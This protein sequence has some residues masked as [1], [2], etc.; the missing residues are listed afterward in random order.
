MV[1]GEG[2][3]N[4]AIIFYSNKESGALEVVEEGGYTPL[5]NRGRKRGT[6]FSSGVLPSFLNLKALY[7]FTCFC[8]IP[9][10]MCYFG[11]ME[12]ESE[13]YLRLMTEAAESQRK[14]AKDPNMASCAKAYRD[15]FNS[16][17]E[18][19]EDAKN[20]EA[21]E[22][23]EDAFGVSEIKI[24]FVCLGDEDYARVHRLDDE[25]AREIDNADPADKRA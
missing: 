2:G 25:I 9:S 18:M 4:V 15:L 7:S 8:P 16:Y 12:R 21:Q 11:N 24:T 19:Y 20:R 10:R 14:C 22:Q 17:K 1:L 13:K 3:E 5:G 23:L 6:S